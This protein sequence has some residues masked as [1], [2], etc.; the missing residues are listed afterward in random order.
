MILGQARSYVLAADQDPAHLNIEQIVTG[1]KEGRVLV[2]MGLLANMTVN[3]QYR[4]GDLATGLDGKMN[5]SV[6]VTGPTWVRATEKEPFQL[7]VYINGHLQFTKDQKQEKAPSVKKLSA[8]F[9]LTG[10]QFPKHDFWMVAVA[11]GPGVTD[12]FWAIPRPYQPSSKTVHSQ[13]IAVTNPIRID[14][15]G[16]G[17]YS[18]PRDY[19]K[20][21]V[22]QHG[23]DPSTLERE[24]KNFDQAIAAQVKSLQIHH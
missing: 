15:D 3:E 17:K 2:S 21:L 11:T 8:Q 16:D 10:N 18:S 4:V 22:K 13:V 24:L 5:V 14:A 1:Y 7:N 12:P 6:D 19:A 20:Q 23:S 9:E